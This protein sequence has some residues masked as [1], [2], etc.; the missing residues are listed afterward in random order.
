M[1]NLPE[2]KKDMKMQVLRNTV[3]VG[4]NDYEFAMFLEYCKATKLNPFKREIWAIKTKSYTNNRGEKV[5]GKLQL[6]TGINGFYSIANSHAQYD[7]IEFEVKRN[8]DGSIEYCEAKV[9]R[10]D[11]TRPSTARVYFREFYKPG[12]FGKESNW[13]KMPHVMIVKVA[14]AHALREAFPQE[15]GNL[16]TPEEMGTEPPKLSFEDVAQLNQHKDAE[17]VEQDIEEVLEQAETKQKPLTYADIER[18]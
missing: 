17:I 6:F 5:E 11:R 13:D 16:Y 10:K 3:A 12:N 18:E 14:K 9:Y 7:N 4:L 2:K 15:L 8:D 1:N